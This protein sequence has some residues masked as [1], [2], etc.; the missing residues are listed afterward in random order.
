MMTKSS[1]LLRE[2]LVSAVI[3]GL[4]SVAFF[5]GTFSGIDPVPVW[6]LGN[7]AF[8]FI[9]QSFAVALMS[10]LVP[11]FLARMA[12]K[13]GK[14]GSRPVPGTGTI[15]VRAFAWA[16][17]ALAV[18]A[19]AAALI[20]WLVAAVSIPWSPAFAIKIVYG[21]LLGAVVTHRSVGRLIG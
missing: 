11:G 2:S 3:N 19:G 1:Y 14:F 9:P 10:A 13:S 16:L 7:Y 4:I 15:V 20:L 18:G 8:D 12:L 21:A 5:L 6:G 17:G